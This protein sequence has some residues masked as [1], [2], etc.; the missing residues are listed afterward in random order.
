MTY[1]GECTAAIGAV[2]FRMGYWRSPGMPEKI[3]PQPA[4]W[5]L[6]DG[7]AALRWARLSRKCGVAWRPAIW[8]GRHLP[9]CTTGARVAAI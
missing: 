6:T 3:W 7:N 8:T 2:R 5:G 1:G 4:S 9:G